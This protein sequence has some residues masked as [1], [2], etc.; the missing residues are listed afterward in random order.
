MPWCLTLARGFALL[1]SEHHFQ[2]ST[3][4]CKIV[5]SLA[6]LTLTVCHGLF[7]VNKTI[8][9]A[10]LSTVLNAVTLNLWIVW[11]IH[12]L[13]RRKNTIRHLI[14]SVEYLINRSGNKGRHTALCA[15]INLALSIA[16]WVTGIT[17]MTRNSTKISIMVMMEEL[18]YQYPFLFVISFVFILELVRDNL[19]ELACD[20]IPFERTL[21]S[22][23]DCHSGLL[24]LCYIINEVYNRQILCIVLKIFIKLIFQSYLIFL[25]ITERI[26]SFEKPAILVLGTLLL[27]EMLLLYIIVNCAELTTKSVNIFI[28]SNF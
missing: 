17:N 19:K 18:E 1:P 8:T 27:R 3:A 2:R 25:D 6:F 12:V 14:G 21:M 24:H 4:I 9:I 23:M 20:L 28:S 22:K 10:F 26:K 7:L 11:H 15:I 5:A 13:A 16:V